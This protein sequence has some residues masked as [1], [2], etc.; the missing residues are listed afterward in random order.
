M[1]KALPP[2]DDISISTYVRF[3]LYLLFEIPSLFCSIFV[4]FY[5]FHK[6]TL[7]EAINNH[8]IIVL[9]LLNFIVQ[10]IDLPWI[11]NYYRLGYVTPSTPTFCMIWIFVDETLYTATTVLFSWT[12]I[13]RHILIFHSNLVSTKFKR[14]LF[15]YTPMI[16][17]IIYC[18]TY[19][20][21]VALFPP[22]ENIFDYNSVVCGY[23]LCYTEHESIGM[24]DISINHVIATSGI[25][26]GCLVLLGR[27][28][29]Q[30][31]RFR[32]PIRWRQDRK[33]AIQLLSIAVLYLILYIP[34]MLIEIAHECCLSEDIGSSF[35]PY[36]KFFSYYV[37]FLLPFVCAN[38]LP[39]FKEKIRRI[40]LWNT[41]CINTVVPHISDPQNTINN[42][43]QT[44]PYPLS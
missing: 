2:H 10:V 18:L 42:Q 9:L 20:L 37:N 39:G 38:S 3:W 23:P 16:V 43:V 12:S 25:I 32:R 26:L 17:L 7:R 44:R 6:R 15:H 14:L 24:W 27:I 35:L 5:L 33:M 4:L 8:M 1:L 22:C 11:M 30:K 31:K 34:Q 41:C 19:G 13:E 40:I 29:Y 28:I 36:A 21:I